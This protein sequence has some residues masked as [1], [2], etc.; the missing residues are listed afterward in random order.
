MTTKG[1]TCSCTFEDDSA[2]Y[3]CERPVGHEGTHHYDFAWGDDKC[4]TWQHNTWTPSTGNVHTRE[5]HRR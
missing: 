5:G 1:T 2:V 4:D 3:W